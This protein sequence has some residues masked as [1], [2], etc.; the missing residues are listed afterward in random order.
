MA[1][2]SPQKPSMM[3]NEVKSSTNQFYR[4]NF[5]PNGLY[6]VRGYLKIPLKKY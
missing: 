1:A 3:E 4:Y 6:T 2:E 5:P